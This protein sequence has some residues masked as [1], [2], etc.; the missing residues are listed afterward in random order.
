LLAFA[1]AGGGIAA[2]GGGVGGGKDDK[3]GCMAITAVVGKG[4]FDARYVARRRPLVVVRRRGGAG[5]GDLTTEQVVVYT[6]S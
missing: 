5:E 6:Y 2:T 1:T 4:D 3:A